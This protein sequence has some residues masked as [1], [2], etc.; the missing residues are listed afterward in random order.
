M[1][2]AELKKRVYKFL[3]NEDELIFPVDEKVDLDYAKEKKGLSRP[4]C[5][6]I[7]YPKNYDINAALEGNV[8]FLDIPMCSKYDFFCFVCK[9][10]KNKDFLGER[11]REIVND[12]TV[13][14]SYVFKT[15][16][17]VKNEIEVFASALCQFSNIEPSTFEDNGSI[18]KLKIIGIWSKNRVEWLIT[19]L[20][21]S[22]IDF[23]TVPLYDTMGINSVKYIFDKTKMEVCCIESEKLE[24]LISIR[25]E[26]KYL[27]I[28]I[29]YDEWNINEELVKKAESVGYKI[30]F[31]KN[32]IDKYKNKNIVCELYNCDKKKERW[33]EDNIVD[34]NKKNSTELNEVE[35]EWAASDTTVANHK[36]NKIRKMSAT[37]VSGDDKGEHEGGKAQESSQEKTNKEGVGKEEACK[38]Q[39]QQDGEDIKECEKNTNKEE[40]DEQENDIENVQDITKGL[41]MHSS[42]K[43][44]KDLSDVN[45]LKRRASDRN[46]QEGASCHVKPKKPNARDVCSIIF[47]SGSTGTPKGVMLSHLNFITFIQS[48]IV[49]GNRLGIIKHDCILSYLPLAHAYERY[50]EYAICFFGAKIGYF[51][52]NIKDILGDIN[53]LKPTFLIAVPRILQK[54]YDNIMEGLRAKSVLA[55]MLVKTAIKKKKLLYAKNP[56][57]FS[58]GFYDLI[59]QPIRN[60]FGGALRIQVMGSSSMDN[61]KLV[62]LQMIFSTPISEGWGMSEVGIGFLQHRFDNNKGT[63]GGPFANVLMKVSKVE[64]MKYD[65]K[66]T[67]NQGEL[68]VKGSGVMLGYFRDENLT[69]KSFDSDGFFFT[70]D[71]AEICENGCVKIIDRAKNIFKLSQGEYVEPEKLE[72]IYIDS[73]YI[74][75]IFVHG[76]SYKNEVVCIIVPSRNNIVEHAKKNNI[77]DTYEELLKSPVINKLI[78]EELI[79]IAAKYKLNGIERARLFHL[80][81]TPFSVENRQLTPTHKIVRNVIVEDYK[82]IIDDLYNVPNPA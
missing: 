41:E 15:Y 3:E 74:D 45:V 24:N 57:K 43:G 61:T 40:E 80:T 34:G 14:G 10:Y 42:E 59:L 53:E 12:K 47:T 30:Y 72:N 49:D 60:R 11:K 19:D 73:P 68:C 69:K 66:G 76:Y 63:I 82:K 16:A 67:P 70:G 27:E 39:D 56:T 33:D 32:L 54:I 38:K 44:V 51:S 25:E 75:Q 22:A 52:G 55:R 1:A 81:A 23:V 28:I 64:Q 31:Y 46:V 8:G 2:L 17:Q 13:F 6:N 48:Y 78:G 5:S 35:K 37:D 4:N 21:C 79:K 9:Y 18:N 29:I 65:P 77:N 50:I 20:A 26:L 62:E 7:Y 58:H 36:K 71:I